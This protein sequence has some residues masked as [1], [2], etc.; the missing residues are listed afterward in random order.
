MAG[1]QCRSLWNPQARGGADKPRN[2]I[3]ANLGFK[4]E[5]RDLW[6]DKDLQLCT[7]KCCSSDHWHGVWCVLP[8]VLTHADL[9]TL[10]L[11]F[12]MHSYLP[13]AWLQWSWVRIPD[14]S[15]LVSKICQHA[16]VG[17]T[18]RLIIKDMHGF[19]LSPTRNWHV[20]NSLTHSLT[21][22]TYDMF[23]GIGTCEDLGREKI[24]SNP[25][26]R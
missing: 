16:L 9:I 1:K 19:G 20:S 21:W 7:M 12:P 6:N 8:C 22:C 23:T 14:L 11:Q 25:C 26:L 10:G 17:F 3:R 4:P 13:W 5:T 2:V 18:K 15:W 24:F